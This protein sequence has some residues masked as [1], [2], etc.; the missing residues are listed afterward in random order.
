MRLNFCVDCMAC[1]AHLKPGHG[2]LMAFSWVLWGALSYPAREQLP[3]LK[4]VRRCSMM[5]QASVRPSQSVFRGSSQRG[6]T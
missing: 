2:A 1:K 6:P 3:H 5:S 4:C